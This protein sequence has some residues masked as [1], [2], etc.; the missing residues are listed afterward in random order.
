MKT[1]VADRVG[2]ERIIRARRE[3]LRRAYVKAYRAALKPRL[4]LVKG[5]KRKKRG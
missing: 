1:T 2:Y 5:K 4:K 3:E